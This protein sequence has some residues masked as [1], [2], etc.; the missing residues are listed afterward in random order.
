MR[1][2]REVREVERKF[3]DCALARREAMVLSKE[4]QATIDSLF[5]DD[6]DAPIV[7][8]EEV[9]TM[10]EITERMKVIFGA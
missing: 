4:A 2:F 6:Y 8:K 9:P 7:P 5:A 1:R 10:E 3:E